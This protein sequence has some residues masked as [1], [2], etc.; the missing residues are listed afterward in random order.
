MYVEV[1]DCPTTLLALSL[2]LFLSISHPLSLSLVSVC[3]PQLYTITNTKLPVLVR[4]EQNRTEQNPLT[5][6]RQ[7]T[8]CSSHATGRTSSPLLLL[9]HP[10]PPLLSGDN[11]VTSSLTVTPKF[12]HWLVCRWDR[13]L[14]WVSF[15]R[16]GIILFQLLE[17]LPVRVLAKNSS[18]AS[19][20]SF[21]VTVSDFSSLINCPTCSWSTSGKERILCSVVSGN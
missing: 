8:S 10:F 20:A 6:L 11:M 16:K 18:M 5:C 21:L 15:G 19:R 9:L 7:Q 2:F 12:P 3:R 13:T 14:C 17:R 1:N 4:T